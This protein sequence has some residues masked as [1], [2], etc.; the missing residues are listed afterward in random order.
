MKERI[1]GWIFLFTVALPLSGAWAEESGGGGGQKFAFQHDRMGKLGRGWVNV[2]ASP[3]ETPM[4]LKG[5]DKDPGVLT[6][7]ISRLCQGTFM[8][9]V[10]ILTGAYEILTFPSPY[11]GDYAPLIQPEFS[12]RVKGPYRSAG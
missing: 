2:F 5:V 7:L 4:A 6:G 1:F 3:L 10:R 12:W 8:T 11:P 9:C